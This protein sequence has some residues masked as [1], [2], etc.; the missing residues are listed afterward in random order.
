MLPPLGVSRP[1]TSFA[2]VVLPQPDSPTT[3]RV[4]PLLD[5]RTR[6]RPPRARCRGCHR[7]NRA[8]RENACVSPTASRTAI[9]LLPPTRR[10]RPALASQ[11]RAVLTVA[12][13]RSDGG[14]S[15]A[16]AIERRRA[17]WREGAAGRQRGKVGRLALD[18][19]QPL[20]AVAHARD[21]VQQRL[22][23]RMRGRIENARHRTGFHH[24]SGVHHR[25]LVAHLGD[26]AEI[27]GDEDQRQAMLALQIRAADSGTAPGSSGRGWWSARRRSAGAART[28]CRSRRRCAGACR[29]TFR[30]GIDVTRVSGEA[31]RTAFNR[32][33]ARRHAVA[34]GRAF[35]HADRLGDL[36]ADR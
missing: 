9:T 19:G 17:A 4:L 31:M 16:A 27:M 28:T 32:S 1:S 30:A 26:D 10:P 24:A 18:R 13:H 6:C 35:M 25:K 3:P 8:G 14:A 7:T 11:Q 5:R 33:T 22:G 2:V 36:V 12:E 23:V 20:A 21:R 29:R 34:R 15:D